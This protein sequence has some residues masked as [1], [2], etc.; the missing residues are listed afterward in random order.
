MEFDTSAWLLRNW[1]PVIPKEDC[2]E[3]LKTPKFKAI[4]ASNTEFVIEREEVSITKI[5]PACSAEFL[6]KK[7]SIMTIEEDYNS[8]MTPP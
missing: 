5:T 1:V 2:P 8:E 3:I 6:S 7:E 4:F